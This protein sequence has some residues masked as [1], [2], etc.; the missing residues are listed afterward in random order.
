MRLSSPPR[1]TASA[2]WSPALYDNTIA[3]AAT[4]ADDMPWRGSCR[5]GAVDVSA[6]GEDVYRGYRN[7]PGDGTTA[8]EPSDGTSYATAMVAGAAALWLGHH[9]RNSIEAARRP[10]ETVHD[11]FLRLVVVTADHSASG[12]DP[13]RFGSGILDVHALL[14]AD[15][16]SGPPQHPTA[17]EPAAATDKVTLLARVLD[18]DP[19]S[20]RA[21]LAAVLQP[22]QD[23]DRFAAEFLELAFRDPDGV[24]AILD[25]RD[26]DFEGAPGAPPHV[27]SLASTQ[28]SGALR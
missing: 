7:I 8:V 17:L 3:V 19:A 24:A 28:L 16:G 23:P 20:T 11:V 5:G 10:G 27:R 26:A 15:L 4:N 22:G 18:R 12:W 1:A 21:A 9:R 25:A 13:K 14:R 2:S 6:P